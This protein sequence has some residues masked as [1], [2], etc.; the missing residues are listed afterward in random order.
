MTATPE[1]DIK[2]V[3]KEKYAAAARQAR[4]C[5]TWAP[6]ARAGFGDIDLEVTRVYSLEDARGF[7]GSSG[8][9]ADAIAQQ[10]EGKL[11]SAFVRARKP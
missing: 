8:I 3:V 5:S 7:P 11:A 1:Q 10:T 6:A 2:G 9:D 4:P